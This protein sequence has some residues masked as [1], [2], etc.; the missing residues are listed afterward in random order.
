MRILSYRVRKI[1]VEYCFSVFDYVA[2][3]DFATRMV[4]VA[5]PP[6]SCVLL[7]SARNDNNNVNGPV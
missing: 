5:R 7:V 6:N 4:A 2:S 3:R 1:A